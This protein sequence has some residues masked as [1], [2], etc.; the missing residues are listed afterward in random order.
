[1]KT[2][3]IRTIVDK[4]GGNLSLAAERLGINRQTLYNQLRKL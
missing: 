2:A 4:C 1:V 3:H